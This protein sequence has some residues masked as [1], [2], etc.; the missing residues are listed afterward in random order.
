MQGSENTQYRSMID[1]VSGYVAQ[2]INRVIREFMFR[3]D[4]KFQWKDV[5]P[6]EDKLQQVQVDQG[7]IN[8]GVYGPDYVQDRLGISEKYRQ[9]AKAAVPNQSSVP[10]LPPSMMPYIKS[11]VSAEL[12]RWRRHAVAFVKGRTKEKFVSEIIP[13]DLQADISAQLKKCATADEAADLFDALLMDEGKMQKAIT[14]IVEDPLTHVKRGAEME[15]EQALTQYFAELKQR[16]LQ[17]AI[18]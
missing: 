11:G 6:Q 18:E 3:R 8:A 5:D 2:L 1:P 7:Y 14:Q 17:S 15:M 12:Q 13:A 9:S 16:V 10:T 4:V